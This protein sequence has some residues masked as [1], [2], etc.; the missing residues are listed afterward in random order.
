MIS[1][2]K[3]MQL[4]GS[5]AAAMTAGTVAGAVAGV[6]GAALAQGT[7]VKLRAQTH[8]S[9]SSPQG[10]MYG[11]WAKLCETLSGGRLKIELFYS[12]AIVKDFET[13]GAAA[14]G[15]LDIDMTGAS[16]QTGKEPA[17]QFVG[18]VMGGYENPMQLH[19][20]LN[21]AGGRKIVDQLYGKFGMHLVGLFCPGVESLSST[22]PL[23]GIDSLKNW[24][25]RSPPGMESEIFKKLG[26]APVVMPFGE[27]F[28]AMS[29]GVVDGCD[30]GTVT[31]NKSLGLYDIAKHIT[32]PGFH[33]MPA[34]HIAINLKKW[35][36]LP[37][38]LKQVMEV[39]QSAI[40]SDLYQDTDVQDHRIATEVAA[41]G[42]T[43]DNWS[44]EDRLKFRQAA[45]EVWKDWAGRSELCKAM[46]DSHVGFM[47]QLG[48]LV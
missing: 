30:A 23:T 26:A 36:A 48:L 35:T 22:K 27:V 24:K 2:R 21:Y 12:A 1:R 28:T 25:F 37:D 33:S 45:Q 34:D 14:S 9:E 13:F 18:D 4:A 15:I 20:W 38:E 19:A 47:R 41:K 46:Y 3:A 42:I 16:Y 31:L 32:Y 5:G 44:R 40:A 17:F 11:R 43:L 10:K 6:P 29:T 39:A 8:M 7:A